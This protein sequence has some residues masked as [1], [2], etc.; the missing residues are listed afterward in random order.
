[1]TPLHLT[2]DRAG[3]RVIQSARTSAGARIGLLPSGCRRRGAVAAA[4]GG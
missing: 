1:M 4:A 3:E 2:A